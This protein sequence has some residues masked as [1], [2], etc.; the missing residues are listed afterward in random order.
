MTMSYGFGGRVWQQRE[1]R[2]PSLL[3]MRTVKVKD[4]PDGFSQYNGYTIRRAIEDQIA[5][6]NASFRR[7]PYQTAEGLK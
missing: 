2:P 5:R 4:G 6:T 1:R 7:R 3:A